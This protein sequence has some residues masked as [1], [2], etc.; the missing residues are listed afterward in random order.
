[1]PDVINH[2]SSTA[3]RKGVALLTVLFIVMAVT[4]ISLGILARSGTELA[5]GR[6]MALRVA[7]DQLAASGLE[8]ARG[9]IRHPQ[10]ADLAEV[11]PTGGYWIGAAGQRLDAASSDF[12]DVNVTLDASDPDERREYTIQCKA[13]RLKDGDEVGSS[14]LS[15]R[16]RLDPCIALWTDQPTTIRPRLTIHGDVRCGENVIYYGTIYG[17]VFASAMTGV[18]G[19]V[20][21]QLNPQ[22]L[23]LSPP[24]VTVA[25]LTDPAHYT[26]DSLT[27]DIL[28]ADLGP[29]DPPH[30]FYRSGNLIVNEGVTVDG[31]LVVDGD[32]TIRGNNVTVSAAKNVP[33]LYV[34]GDLIV[35]DV[36]DLQITGLAIVGGDARISAGAS[37]VQVVG[38]MLLGGTFVETAP[39]SSGN[40]RDLLIRSKPRW[41]TGAGSL[42]LDGIDDMLEDDQAGAYLNGLTAITVSIWVLSHV[43]NQD[44]GIMYAREPTD[45][46]EDLGLRYDRDGAG[47][48]GHNLIKAS[49]RTTAGYM[50]IESRSN[51][52]T[53]AWQHLALVWSSG[54]KVKLY[55]NGQE[56]T[57]LT[58]SRIVPE[59]SV[60]SG[61]ISGV[62]KLI[63]GLGAT[64]APW[65]GHVADVQIYDQALSAGQVW[66]LAQ[67]Y[68]NGLP[69]A[70]AHWGFDE[71]GM[72]VQITADPAKAAIVVWPGGN[73]TRWSP[74]AGAFFKSIQREL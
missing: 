32:L 50:H 40:H 11:D 47:G 7:M 8:H 67:N 21:G 29:Y 16:L 59:A 38:A 55:I 17:D 13:Y 53:T 31:T 10:D 37:H 48:G 71:S 20:T 12:Y 64:G 49:I 15:A 69:D 60:L 56:D 46:D 24:D 23:S 3:R 34:T 45:R 41:V 18:S 9:L 42:L 4:V 26:V 28:S 14:R 61:S 36:D 5:S 74:A 33:A 22:S 73:R 68:L 19:G 52:Q 1:M 65:D 39:D 44:R 58:Y 72:E 70:I 62:Q 51:V 43:T 57:W 25:D 2:P 54:S 6:N 63:I 27:A 66:W 35:E 30:V